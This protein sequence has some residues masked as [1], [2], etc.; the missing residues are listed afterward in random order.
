MKTLAIE[1][2][3]DDTSLWI[4]EFKLNKFNPVKVLLHSQINDHKKFGWVVPELASRLHEEKIMDLLEEIWEKEI[5]NVNFISYT[6]C[7]WLP[8]SLLVWTTLANTLSVFLKKKKLPI[9]H[10]HWHIFSIFIERNIN[11][12]KFPL[13]VL[14]VSGWHNELYLVDKITNIQNIKNYKLDKYLEKLANNYWLKKSDLIQKVWNFI[15]YKLGFTLDDA[16]W[17]AFDKVS[18]M[19]WWPYPWWKWIYDK[20]KL[21]ITNDEWLN[22]NFEFSRIWLKKNEFN[23]SFSGLKAQVNY[24]IQDLEKKYWKITSI[25]QSKIA[26]EF[27]EAVVETLWKKLLKSTD[28]FGVKNIAI[29]WWVSANLRLKNFIYQNMKKFWIKNFYTPVKPLYS[30]DNAAMIGVVGLL[31][32]IKP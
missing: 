32:I 19:L 6:C 24:K 26:Y 28:F 1:T 14:T 15:L 9:N 21:L 8:W 3:C 25:L 18:K 22:E 20:S 2:S 13:I 4:I 11:E 31:K 10:I 30:T 12:I 23:F 5:R 27:Q 7:P 16:A 17:E 29:V